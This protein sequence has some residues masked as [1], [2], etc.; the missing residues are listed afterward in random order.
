M[1]RNAAASGAPSSGDER[2]RRA[3]HDIFF[4]AVSVT[5]MPMIV[6]DPNQRDQPIVYANPAFLQM[7]GYREDELIGRN[8]RFLQGPETDR[9]TVDELRAAIAEQRETAVEILNYKKSGASFWNALFMSP[10]FD[11]EGRLIY[12]FGSQLDVSRRKDAEDGLRQ[13]QKMEA[14]GHLTGG[15]AHDFNNLLQVIQG[16]AEVLQFQLDRQ[17]GRPSPDTARALS[18]ILKAAERGT[19]LTQQLLAFARKQQLQGRVIDLN[20]MVLSFLPL[21]ERVIGDNAIELRLE[22]DEGALNVRI[23]STQA[24][25]SVMNLVINAR[26]AMPHGGSITLRTLRREVHRDEAV[27][28]GLPPGEYAELAVVDTGTGMAPAVLARVTEPFFTTKEPGKGTGLGLSM[29]FGFAKQ[30]G[31]ALRIES[32]PGAGTTAR[33]F[34]P[35]QLAEAAR[36]ST[37]A[38]TARPLQT[39]RGLECVLVVEDQA[40][41]GA[42]AQHLLEDLGY[43]V[44]RAANGVEAL[45]LLDSA[46]RVDLLFT[47]VIMP[48]GM[49]GVVLAREARRR[50]PRIKV[51]L[52][53]GFADSALDRLDTSGAEFESLAKPYRRADLAVRVRQTLDGPTGVG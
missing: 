51:L 20:E 48:G 40:D 2:F 44:M 23:D 7:T 41:V 16:F 11:D 52:T 13:A 12:Y 6:T 46:E 18:S 4:A 31:G 36:A 27:A 28:G 49:N 34:F 17:S 22:L 5:R 39:T 42:L 50:R 53:T 14:I 9:E 45:A 21:I 8:C 10:V 32:E 47:D 19:R 37:G 24:E 30:S 1:D 43:R 26:D 38:P 3:R 33:V 29:V 25:L 35:L 15:V